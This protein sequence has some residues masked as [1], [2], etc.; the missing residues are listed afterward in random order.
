MHN[1]VV[2]L[3]PHIWIEIKVSTLI[4]FPMGIILEI[5]RHGGGRSF[6]DQ[7]ALLIKYVVS[8][9]IIGLHFH[10]Q[11]WTLQLTGVNRADGITGSKAAIDVR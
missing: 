8:F 5:K 7:F 11:G 6:T 4:L 9:L 2:T 1:D 3:A 10:G